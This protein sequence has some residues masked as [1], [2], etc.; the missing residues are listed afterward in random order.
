MPRPFPAYKK[1]PELAAIGGAIRDLRLKKG[2]S[3]EALAD[4]AGIDRSY[5]GGVERGEHNLAVINLSKIAEALGVKPS[6]LI[7]KAGL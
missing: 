4:A 6:D 3:Q 7:K 2:L 1:H 5:L